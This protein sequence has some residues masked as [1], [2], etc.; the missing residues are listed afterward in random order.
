MKDYSNLPEKIYR[1]LTTK[2]NITEEGYILS[3]AFQFSEYN[4]NE[5]SGDDYRELSI[6]WGDDD[7]AKKVLLEQKKVGRD[8]LQFKAG[9]C[10]IQKRKVLSLLQCYIE[11]EHFHMERS[12][13]EASEYNGFQGNKYHGN[14]LVSNKL[15]KALVKNVENCLATLA[16]IEEN[17]LN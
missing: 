12:P 15:R 13:V 6:N 16:Y 5:R 17:A 1:G 4:A 2:D 8:E 14:F 11:R 7:G 10:I 9:Y 3:S